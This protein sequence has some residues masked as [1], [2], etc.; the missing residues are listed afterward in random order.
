M[1]HPLIEVRGLAV[2]ET[3]VF[4]LVKPFYNLVNIQIALDF[5]LTSLVNIHQMISFG[6]AAYFTA[7]TQTNM[8][9]KQKLIYKTQPDLFMILYIILEARLLQVLRNVLCIGILGETMIHKL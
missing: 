1:V 8:Q 3:K 4:Q 7:G 9:E 2:E 5:L 6:P